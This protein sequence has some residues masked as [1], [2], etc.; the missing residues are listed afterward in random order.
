MLVYAL[1]VMAILVL[2]ALTLYLGLLVAMP[3]MVIST[4]V[5]YTEVFEKPGDPTP[6]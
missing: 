6:A 4:F 3:V 5:G 1:A 2:S